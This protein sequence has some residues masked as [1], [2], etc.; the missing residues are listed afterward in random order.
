[1]KWNALVVGSGPN[2]L[3][4]AIRLSQAGWRVRVAESA[5]KPG[6]GCRTA[7]L[8]LPG[9]C[10]DVCAAA[11]PL[12]VASPYFRSLNLYDY[13]LNW[14]NPEVVLAHPTLDGDAAGLYR[15]IVKTT[16]GLGADGE[17]WAELISPLVEN[18]DDLLED[19]LRPPGLP[20]HPLVTGRFALNALR[21]AKSLADSFFRT[22]KAKTLFCGLAAHAKLPLT[23]SISASF[24][25]V[26]G[27]A[28]HA[29]GWPVA[30]GGSAKIIDALLATLTKLGGE[31]ITDAEVTTASDIEKFAPGAK[32]ALFDITPRQLLRIMGDLGPAAYRAKLS[33]FRYGSGVFKLDYALSE[34]IPWNNEL[35]RKAG[36]VHLGSSAEEIILSEK[37]TARGRQ[38]ERPYVI[39]VQ[40]T[41][42]DPSRAPE[43]KHI[44]WAY[45]HAPAASTTDIT[46]VVE[47]QIDR[48][49]KGFRDTIL[50]RHLMDSMAMEKYNPNYIGG[51]IGS[52]AQDLRQTIW[53]P[54]R[55]GN[56]YRMPIPGWYICSASTPPGG[57]VHGMCGFN[58][59][60][61]VLT[62]A[63]GS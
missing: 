54:F 26:L 62:D 47:N 6:G 45:C 5:A 32:T 4:A 21:S 34:Q 15:S 41:L 57:G 1:M 37:C 2:G 14:K 25:L 38:P 33:A 13:G 50:G 3:A 51:D 35:C 22:Q 17:A 42:V 55:T 10:H 52:G 58:A 19:I 8:T 60:E 56:P 11:H 36:T 43:G 31:V 20:A 30:E 44:A 59:A 40:P 12:G 27:A 9:F 7:D 53:R 24:G 16:A 46:R 23:E 49:A 61:Q 18:F 39:V 28:A 29:V 48:Y 63:G